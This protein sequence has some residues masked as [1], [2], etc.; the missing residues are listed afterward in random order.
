MKFIEEDVKKISNLARIDLSQEEAE[1]MRE[2]LGGILEY[3][4]KIGEVDT[5]E[6]DDTEVDTEPRVRA[7]AEEA[8]DEQTISRIVSQFPEQQNDALLVPGV[9]ENQETGSKK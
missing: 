9:F 2:T 5:S 4:E 6:V 8:C 1:R 3:V 7:D